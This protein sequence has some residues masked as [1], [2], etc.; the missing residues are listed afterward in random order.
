MGSLHSMGGR[1]AGLYRY[2]WGIYWACVSLGIL[3]FLFAPKVGVWLLVCTFVLAW[4][5]AHWPC[6]VCGR[7]VGTK[8]H[9]VFYYSSIP[10]VRHCRHCSTK[11]V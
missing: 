11:L 10:G 2:V 4:M 1:A 3:V 7:Q 5:V 6:P 8:R 9:V